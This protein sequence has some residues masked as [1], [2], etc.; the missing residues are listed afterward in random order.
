L[1]KA[2][3]L[4]K[5][6]RRASKDFRAKVKGLQTAPSVDNLHDLRTSIRR[7]EAAVNLFPKNVRKSK[8]MKKFLTPC[9]K[10][11]RSTTP[12]RDIDVVL[13]NITSYSSKDQ[14]PL[15]V[16]K[17][18]HDRDPLVSNVLHFAVSLEEID[19][20]KI[21]KTD[22]ASREIAKRRNKIVRRLVAKIEE[23]LP[24]VLGDFRKIKELH[25]IRKECKKLRYILEL[26]PSDQN[27]HLVGLMRNWQTILGAIRDIDVTQQFAE[28]K[29]LVEDLEE[30]L[31]KLRISRE[32]MLGSFS[33]SAR[34][35]IS[36]IPAEIG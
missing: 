3:Q 33:S 34:L 6:Y 1:S 17:I 14:L 32:K 12:V 20:P 23:E 24:I 9:R 29:G 28:E 18:N 8:K 30:V 26:F 16:S 35:E 5:G 10:L 19:P 21:T 4:S 36:L 22:L 13:Q 31:T 11:F 25:D 2:G 27:D 7:L 15:I